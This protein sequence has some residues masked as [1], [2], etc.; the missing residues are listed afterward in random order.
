[1]STKNTHKSIIITN[2]AQARLKS[3]AL[4]ALGNAQS[5]AQLASRYILEGVEREESRKDR[6]TITEGSR[7]KVSL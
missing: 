5:M 1:M 3:H 4:Y 7:K 2:E 6:G